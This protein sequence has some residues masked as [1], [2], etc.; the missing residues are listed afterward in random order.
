MKVEIIGQKIKAIRKLT[1][2]ELEENGWDDDN[3][4]PIYALELE[5]GVVIYPS[6]DFEGNGGGALF[7]L[8]REKGFVIS[9]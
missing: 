4:N 9:G 1:D 5:N 8:D 3:F 7:G 2:A 6:R